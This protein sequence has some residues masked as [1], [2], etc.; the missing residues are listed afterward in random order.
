M[1]CSESILDMMYADLG[2]VGQDADHVEPQGVEMWFSSVEVVFGYGAQGLLLAGGDGLQRVSEAG[3]APQFHFHEDER[4][5]SN[6]QTLAT[7][8]LIFRAQL[9]EDGALRLEL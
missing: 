6:L 9:T 7:P 5:G 1:R 4:L 3:T 8:E 2:A